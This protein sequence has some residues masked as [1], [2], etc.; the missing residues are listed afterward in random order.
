MSRRHSYDLGEPHHTAGPHDEGHRH[1]DELGSE[2]PY[3]E[4]R[5][6]EKHYFETR[7]SVRYYVETRGSERHHADAHGSEKHH[8]HAPA[9]HE[10]AG[11]PD[12]PH[13]AGDGGFDWSHLL[14]GHGLS[15]VPFAV[16]P[17]DH[18]TLNNNSLIQNFITENN[19]IVFNAAPG[20]EID[21]GGNVNAISAQQVE[22]Q[23]VSASHGFGSELGWGEPAWGDAGGFDAVL[24]GHLAGPGGAPGPLVLMPVEHL[25]INNNTLVQNFEVENTNITF[26]AG[27]GGTI[28]VDGSVNAISEQTGD[29][30]HDPHALLG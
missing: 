13:G 8:A 6:S 1:A 15:G 24:V 3:V 21:V 18:L 26:N 2:R 29:F 4:T 22:V 23:S 25:E 27:T 14:D 30:G 19:S 10:P 17:I 11:H 7:D 5:G 9:S 16:M 12:A 28:D 20:S